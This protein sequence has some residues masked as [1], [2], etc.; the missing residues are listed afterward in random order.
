M[1]TI[2]NIIGVISIALLVYWVFAYSLI[3]IFQLKVFKR[4]ITEIFGYSIS[5]ILALMFGALMLN[6]MFNL[7]RIAEKHNDDVIA[8][9]KKRSKALLISI[10][11]SFPLIACLLFVGDNLTTIKREKVLVELASEKIE[12]FKTEFEEIL[13]YDFS[14]EWI[15][16]T[17]DML[18][19][20][21]SEEPFSI[22]VSDTINGNTIYLKFSSHT[23]LSDRS[24]PVKTHHKFN[25]SL[26]ERKYL[27]NVFENG[28][29]KHLFSS[30][31]GKY[32]LFFPYK[33]GNKTIVLW[34]SNRL[35]YGKIGS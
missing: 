10:I 22:I 14:K 13:N 33:K 17:T 31:H 24:E 11:F 15:A 2:S 29:D 3:E 21:D 4:N 25:A 8:N 35:E 26:E 28:Y 23:Y 19:Y 30:D 20:M 9:N 7:T 5:G 34:F 16:N 27:N 12:R 6:V 1:V 18:N 32:K